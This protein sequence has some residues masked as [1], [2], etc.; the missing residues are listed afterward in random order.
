MSF[1]FCT[2][3]HVS[4]LCTK[5]VSREVCQKHMAAIGQAFA[6]GKMSND[7]TYVIWFDSRLRYSNGF[8]YIH[9]TLISF[10]AEASVR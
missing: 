2:D 6:V 10:T 7:S 8:K 1:S 9:Y 3:K 5:S 4:N